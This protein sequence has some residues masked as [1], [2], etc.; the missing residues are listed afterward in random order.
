MSVLKLRARAVPRPDLPDGQ[1]QDCAPHLRQ[2]QGGA[3]RGQGQAGDLRGLRQH[4]SHPQELQ[5]AVIPMISISK[6]TN[7][8]KIC[9]PVCRI[10]GKLYCTK[11]YCKENYLNSRNHKFYHTVMGKRRMIIEDVTMQNK[12]KY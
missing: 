9:N 5:E 3:D 11:T 4:L 8:L 10:H 6:C 12:G 1:A 7:Q 2:W